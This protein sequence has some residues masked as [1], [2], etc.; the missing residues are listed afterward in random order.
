MA[1][2]KIDCRAVCVVALFTTGLAGGSVRSMTL[3]ASGVGG[4]IHSRNL[5]AAGS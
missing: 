5:C 4:Q 1:V 2:L 3:L